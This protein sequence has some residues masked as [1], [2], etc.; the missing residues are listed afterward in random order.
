MA[1]KI[2]IATKHEFSIAQ[3]SFMEIETW[4]L[5]RTSFKINI[6]EVNLDAIYFNP[7]F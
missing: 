2:K 7:T 3:S 4:D 5:E 6:V 1:D